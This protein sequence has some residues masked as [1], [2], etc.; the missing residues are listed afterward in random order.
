MY[1]RNQ[2]KRLDKLWSRKIVE[3]DNGICQYCRKMGDNPHHI[4]LKRYMAVRHDLRNGVCLC[5][6]CHVEVAHGQPESFTEWI[7]EVM[8]DEYEE[9][10]KKSQEIKIDLNEVE[11]KLKEG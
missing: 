4:I 7:M 10:R 8:G 5:T 6:K 2:I 11:R 1:K 9:L 3:R